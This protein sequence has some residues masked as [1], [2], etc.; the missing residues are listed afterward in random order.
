[1]PRL[2]RLWISN[3][4]SIGAPVQIA[5]PV[6]TPVV[7]VG[8]N[9][10]GKS[11]I[12]RALDLVLGPSWPASHDPDDNEFHERDREKLI[13]VVAEFDPDS[14][15][16]GLYSQVSWQCDSSATPAVTFRG[17]TGGSGFIS[18][19][20]RSTCMCV[21]IEAERNLNYHLSYASR[22]TLLSRLMHRFHK[23]LTEDQTT[24]AE[25]EALF[26]QVRERFNRIQPFAEFT[27]VLRTRLGE[28]A[29]TMTHRL[30]VDF[31]AYNPVNFFHALRLHATE[32]E[33]RRTL[34]E[35][36]TGE[37]QILAL[38]FAYAYATAF[39]EGVL[40]V[41][42]EPEA[43]LHPLAQQWLASRLTRMCD[44]GL[45]VLLTTHSAHFLNMLSLPGLVLVRKEA[46][47][48]AVR[49]VT[50]DELA[51]HCI[52]TGARAARTT[53]SNVLQFYSSSATT[54]LAEGS[55]PRASYLLRVRRRQSPCRS[56]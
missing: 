18:N 44:Q 33:D 49:Q 4:R 38:S 48:T 22:F 10:T 41:V 34:A 20:H 14:L 16:G 47:A 52:R 36:G 51:A 9:N 50:A 35:M 24:R 37:Q 39:H 5:F 29:Q 2:S 11:N 30:E 46:G 17:G 1:M 8:E 28:F 12:V 53:P 43:H 23:A 55:S 15:F 3:Y 54:E 21:V 31:E 32:G 6:D 19:A 25:L 40:L 45:Q 26:A 42:E 56:C 27:E 13:K 7:L